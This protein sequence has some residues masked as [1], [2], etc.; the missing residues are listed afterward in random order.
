MKKITL[1]ILLLIV[2][3]LSGSTYVAAESYNYSPLEESIFSAEAM[4]VE[5]VVDSANLVD[6]NKD[7]VDFEFGELADVFGFEDN[8]YLVDRTSN[9]VHVLNKKYQ[10]IESFGQ[11]GEETLDEPNGIFVT[12]EYIYVADTD[13]FRVAVFN[14]DYTFAFEITAP[15][16][17]TFKQS[18][19]DESGYDFKPLKI[20]VHET[21]RVY[22]VAD[23]IFEGILD[24]NPDGTFSRYVGAN[25]VTLSVMEAFWLNFTSEEQRA[26]QG[27]RLATTFNSVNIDEMGYLYTVS[28]GDE[29]TRVIKKLNYRGIDVLTRN[30]Y[31]EQT[32]DIITIPNNDVVPNEESEFIDIDVNDFDNY[33]VLDATRGRLF[34]YDFEGNLLYVAG[35][36]GSLNQTSNNQ[37]DLFLR[38]EAVTYYKNKV[39]V[40][41]SM[42]KNLVVFGYT[43]FGQLVNEAT[44][45]YFD[46]DYTGAKVKWEEVLRL[47]TNYFLA[48]SGIAKAELREGNYEKAMEY[49]ELGYDDNT[50][51]EAY[52]PYRYDKIAVV[53]PYIIGLVFVSLFYM[54]YKSMKNALERAKEDE[55]V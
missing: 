16:D 19:D 29:G 24:F 1:I 10:H 33:V 25:T 42:N 15:D 52:Q 34:T 28:G 41:D 14:H 8:V 31:I 6:T 40:V 13:H 51:S 45:A 53:F 2:V 30:G 54:F 36:L 22:V 27:Y 20:A 23:Q 48:Y 17:P 32:G 3:A 11:T 35:Q 18:P 50:Y 55:D 26:R 9:L 5:N 38:P 44:N 7:R 43:E 21:G 47:N 12:D 4:I 46:G 37:R 49:A 39:L